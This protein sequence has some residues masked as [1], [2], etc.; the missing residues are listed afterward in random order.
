MQ[1]RAT[2]AAE[3][4][5]AALSSGASHVADAIGAVKD[6]TQVRFLRCLAVCLDC[7]PSSCCLCKHHRALSLVVLSYYMS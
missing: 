2:E 7:W 6:R 5:Q 1:E 4:A 3:A